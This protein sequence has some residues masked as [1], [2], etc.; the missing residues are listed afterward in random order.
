MLNNALDYGIKEAEFWNM[1]FAE[2]DRYIKSRIRTIK[3]ENQEKAKFDYIHAILIGK[4]VSK[5]LS[6]NAT[7]PEIEEA[8]PGLFNNNEKKQEEIQNKK[9]ELS[10]LRFKQFAQ[11]YNSKFKE[12]RKDK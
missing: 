1:T 11:S 8:Y 5:V 4:A 10:A 7:F 9:D 2:I 3:F 12:V 6:S